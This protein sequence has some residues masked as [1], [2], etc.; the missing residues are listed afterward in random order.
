MSVQHFEKS[1]SA[2]TDNNQKAAPAGK[3]QQCSPTLKLHTEHTTPTPRSENLLSSYVNVDIG[4]LMDIRT[5]FNLVY[6]SYNRFS[7][8][9]LIQNVRRNM[10]FG[11]IFFIGFLAFLMYYNDSL[12][13]RIEGPLV[14][15]KLGYVQ[16]ITS[17]SRKGRFFY[18]YLGIPYATPPVGDLRFEPPLPPE[19][20]KGIRD[21]SAYGS[22]CVQIDLLLGVLGGDEDCLTLNVFTPVKFKSKGKKKLL[23]VIVYIHGGFF[24]NGGGAFWRPNYFMDEDVVLV[25]LNYRLNSLGFLNTG[26]G[27]IRG[28]MGM[29]DQTMALRWLKENVE[30]FGGDPNKITVLGESAGGCAA[31]LHMFSKMS[32]GL[33]HNVISESGSTLHFWAVNK[34]PRKQALRYLNQ[35]GCPSENKTAMVECL[36]SANAYDIAEI[37]RE[38]LDPLREAIT[39]FKPSVEV[40]IPDGN[41]FITEHPRDLALRGDYNR[42]PWIMGV[43]S[44][45]GLITS[46]VI[47][48]NKTMAD[49]AKTDW[50]FFIERALWFNSSKGIAA[51]KI[52]NF[53]FGN[54]ADPA[55]VAENPFEAL[56]NYT[57]MISDRGFNHDAHHGARI[58]SKYSP[59]YMYYYSYR[60]EWSAVNYFKEVRG[61]WPR[62]VEVAWAIAAAWVRKNI[63]G[64]PLTNYGASH[65]D[66]LALMFHMPWVSDVT[67]EC[68]DY[69][70]SLDLI[71][72]WADFGRKTEP[73]LF[74]DVEWEP[75]KPWENT[76]RYLKID[77][78]PSMIDEPFTERVKFWDT[79]EED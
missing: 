35:L 12:G 45:E 9:A 79:L 25:T 56:D 44:E 52:R 66:E 11:Q 28:N 51:E 17:V 71:K 13:Q 72:L 64:Q 22:K 57:T 77:S 37:H 68:N 75:V 39:I 53:Y 23:N 4:A 47:L 38:L 15:T 46:A 59:V 30:V 42:V 43:N 1:S 10:S 67:P 33:F 7:S 58:Q 63:L 69:T 78:E 24:H 41:T 14:K 32:Q 21:G 36:K 62:L 27:A 29:K 31:H 65:S 34:D 5:L 40:D 49:K 50:P 60:G 54:N 16:G 2:R 19:P 3:I 61:A 6:S 55:L 20:W 74:R 73:L 26:D 18:E 70:M 48:A 76:V 8:S